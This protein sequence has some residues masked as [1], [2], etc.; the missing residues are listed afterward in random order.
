MTLQEL[1]AESKSLEFNDFS[2]SDGQRLGEYLVATARDGNL[3]ITVD[4]TIG[5]HQIFH[6]AL[7]GTNGE[8]DDWIRRKNNTSMYFGKNSYYVS[9]ELAAKVRQ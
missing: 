1:E 8:N 9:R 7:E 6:Y 4:I 2:I 5:D 3:S